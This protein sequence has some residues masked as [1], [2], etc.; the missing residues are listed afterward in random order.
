[1]QSF[2]PSGIYV[3]NSV[4]SY[5]IT[6]NVLNYFK[7]VPT[8][9]LKNSKEIKNPIPISEAK[10]TLMITRFKGDVIRPC[11]GIGSY[12]CCNYLIMSFTSNC[13]LECTYC[14]LQD[15]LKNNP[16]VTLYANVDEMLDMAKKVIQSQPDK[17]FRVG[18]GELSDSLALDSI[19]HLSK[20]LIPF[21]AD[22][23]NLLL[24]LK[25]KTDQ[26][27]NLLDLDH[28]GKTIVSWS[29]NP[30]KYIEQEELKCSSLDNRL[31]A[32]RDV[33]DAGY[34]IGFHFDPILNFE[35]WEENYGDLVKRLKSDFRSGEI[36]WISIG[37]LRYTPRLKKIIQERFPKSRLLYGE[38]F[39][40]ADGKVRYFREIREGLYKH[41][42][43]M[44]DQAFPEVPNYLCMETKKVWEN[45][46]HEI[47]SIQG[48][49]EKSFV[50]R[51]VRS[52]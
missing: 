15:Y 21:A 42:K 22:Q 37:S 9:F 13:H 25:T 16:A 43:S 17:L 26:V 31:K 28:R 5:E 2:T 14:I 50:E 30:Q 35:N 41:V 52:Y 40:G 19:T 32:A 20:K 27:Q 10:R 3:D 38:L 47:P 7:N 34:P 39:A 48:M 44:L 24:E 33:A 29:V 45:V 12:L 1:M 49:L 4:R 11:Q 8:V 6:R 23:K 46:Y 36:A 18:T 51:F